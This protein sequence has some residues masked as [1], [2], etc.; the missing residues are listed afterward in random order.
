MLCK[1]AEVAREQQRRAPEAEGPGPEQGAGRRNA[2]RLTLFPE[3]KVAR[4]A[5]GG[6]WQRQ[7]FYSS[8]AIAQHHLGQ[9]AEAALPPANDDGAVQLLPLPESASPRQASTCHFRGFP[10]LS[11]SRAK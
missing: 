5:L 6:A 10:P 8:P 9:S 7:S 4:A 1:K 2:H 11:G 3:A